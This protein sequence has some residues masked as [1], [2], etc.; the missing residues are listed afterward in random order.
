MMNCMGFTNNTNWYLWLLII[1]LLCCGGCG[2]ISN[3][4][5][6]ICGCGYLVPILLVLLCC[7]G[8][9]EKRPEPKIF[10]GCTC[11]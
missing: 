5:E 10:P 8:D 7:C 11:K 1:I 2:C 4:L 3:I 9:K 6:K